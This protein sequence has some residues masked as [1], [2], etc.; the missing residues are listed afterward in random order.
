MAFCSATWLASSRRCISIIGRDASAG[1]LNSASG[2]SLASAACR[3]AASS[4]AR[5]QVALQV[6]ELGGVHGGIELDQ[7]VARLDALA[8]AHMDRTHHARLE[9]LD[10]LGAAGG[11]D[12]ARGHGHDVDRA[13]ARPGERGGKHRD[14]GVDDR[15]PDRRRRR[16]DDLERGGQEGELVPAA[17]DAPLGEGDHVLGRLVRLG[18]DGLSGLHAGPPGGGR[19][20]RSGRRS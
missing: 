1:G 3:R 18:R 13:D 12:L 6:P 15:P 20:W 2:S 19:A 11:D 10:G 5:H 9:R 17:L 7:H 4:W 8:V 14:H 16:L